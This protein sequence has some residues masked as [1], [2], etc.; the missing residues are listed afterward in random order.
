MR[1]VSF[2]ASFVDGALTVSG[3]DIGDLGGAKITV[4]RGQI[5]N[6]L[7]DPKGR[8]EGQLNAASVT[9]LSRIVDRL[10]PDTAFSR[11]LMKAAPSLAP[12]AV[13]LVVDSGAT[14]DSKTS[15]LT[16]KGSAAAT[17]FDVT[18]DLAGAPTNWRSSEAKVTASLSSY[19]ALGLAQQVGIAAANVAVSGGARID[20]NAA[21]VPNKGM[22]VSL[23]GGFGGVT[24]SSKGSLLVV[25]D[26]PLA[27][28][29]DFAVSSDNLD[30]LVHM[31]GLDIPGSG[32]G[33]A[34]N[35]AGT[36]ETLGPAADFVLGKGTVAGRQISGKVHVAVG[37]NGGPSLAGA[38]QLDE[39]DLGWIASLGLGYAPFPTD[40]PESPWSKTPFG[41]PLFKTT[42]AKFDVTAE[43]LLVGEGLQVSNP[44]FSVAL[45]PDRVDFDISQGGVVGGTVAGGLSIHNVDGNAS[46]TGRFGLVGG[47]LEDLAWQ[48]SGRSVA[49]GTLDLSANFEATGRS[50]AGLI[51]SL[52]GGGTLAIHDG[53]ARYINPRAVNLVIKA[54]D[55]G[56]QF[57]DDALAGLFAGYIDAGSLGFTEAQAA[58]SIAAGTV[59][60]QNLAVEATDA[61]ATGSAAIDLNTLTLNSDWSLTF[62]AGDV[63]SDTPPPEIGLVFRGPLAAPERI[64]DVLQFTS[65][66][67]IRQEER[68]QEILALEEEARQEKEKFT[69][70]RRKLNED[71]AAREAEAQAA[72]A[73]RIAAVQTLGAFHD[74]RET[75]WDEKA[76]AELAVAI[77]VAEK[78]YAEK[79]AIEEVARAAADAARAAREVADAAK[80]IAVEKAALA[81]STAEAAK[82]LAADRDAAAT[83][84]TE[85]EARASEA[86]RVAAEASTFA[87]GKAAALT[88]AKAALAQATRDREAAVATAKAAA[89]TASAAGAAAGKAEAVANAGAEDAK[90][91]QAV[92]DEKSR[93]AKAAADDVTAAGKDTAAA[94]SQVTATAAVKKIAADSAAKAEA[95]RVAAVKA[96]KV[97]ADL[98]DQAAKDRDVAGDRARAAAAVAKAAS[99]NEAKA[100]GAA[101]AAADQA[102]TDKAAAEKASVALAQAREM[103]SSQPDVNNET[104]LAAYQK[105]ADAA[106][107]AAD[108][109]SARAA[110]LQAAATAA[111]TALAQAEVEAEKTAAEAAARKDAA[112]AL[113]AKAEAARTDASVKAATA[114]A[115]RTAAEQA[116]VAAVEAAQ[117]VDQ[118]QAT[119]KAMGDTVAAL[120]ADADAAQKAADRARAAADGATSAASIARA[121]AMQAEGAQRNA[122]EEASVRSSAEETAA[123]AAANAETGL[124]A[125]ERA[126]A[127]ADGRAAAARQ[128]ADAA[129]V[130]AADKATAEV[131]GS[132]AA[133]KA[134]TE[135]VAAE[136][137][138]V[139]AA[140]RAAEAEA[141]AKAAAEKAAAVPR[142]WLPAGAKVAP[143]APTETRSAPTPALGPVDATGA[144]LSPVA[145]VAPAGPPPTPRARPSTR[146]APSKAPVDQQPMVIV[147]P[148]PQ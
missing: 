141:T 62:D 57:A 54:V 136:R 78:A 90:K 143:V 42:T 83:T 118:K 17:G 77:A 134:A 79:S 30:P 105:D 107:A 31:I 147:P 48:R 49:T 34:A 6:V 59:R 51:S 26:L 8:L 35:L 63:K 100:K 96:A 88:A 92:A 98:A 41:D 55:L 67:N 126:K 60:M 22:A 46:V 99:D 85:A 1:D 23:D 20:L 119:E 117:A 25:A 56:Q 129:K 140:D 47:T 91:A 148:A 102:A 69:R 61:R 106:Q 12:A 87:D 104:V 45:G 81:R 120:A 36:I 112:D 27:Y 110:D 39:V 15:R 64:I 131:D 135:Q 144:T 9:G 109:S 132:A 130:A 145:G 53:E 52:T 128:A 146:K 139:E 71:A 72:A 43:R 80:S 50:P 108:R 65:Y 66:L 97:A 103:A 16:I 111:T 37:A 123:D 32:E 127:D 89:A 133:M 4:T 18:V 76:A 10:F 142:V 38:L 3:V 58:F 2:D 44:K 75:A 73:A 94:G 84:A 70:E 40:D 121:A 24:L 95:E 14:N 68:I 11:W 21:G 19:D 138:S 101:Q 113:A 33:T 125:A 137:A 74:Q 28:K 29:G 114:A 122:E 124:T 5:D 7:T 82:T 93:T 116:A 115:S 86:E 13:S